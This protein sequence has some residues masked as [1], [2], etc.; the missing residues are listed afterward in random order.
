MKCLYLRPENRWPHQFLF[1]FMNKCAVFSSFAQDQN[2]NQKSWNQNQPKNQ[3][4]LPNYKVLNDFC[5]S[6]DIFSQKDLYVWF[7]KYSK[8]GNV[9]HHHQDV[10]SICR[11][12]KTAVLNNTA[13][14]LK[15]QV[16]TP[17]SIHTDR[18]KKHKTKRY[19]QR[20]DHWILCRLSNLWQCFEIGLRSCLRR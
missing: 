13:G 2:Q 7:S 12:Q 14:N 3:R 9:C 20:Q 6:K 11:D 1:Q 4:S 16:Q 5:F 8:I 15:H 10:W 17:Y 18:H 19:N